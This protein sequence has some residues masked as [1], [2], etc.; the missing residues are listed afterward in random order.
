MQNSIN[1]RKFI[2]MGLAIAGGTQI[3]RNHLFSQDLHSNQIPGERIVHPTEQTISSVNNVIFPKKLKANDIIAIVSP[4]S[5]TNRWEVT[6]TVNFLKSLN[7]KVE[8]GKSIT[9]QTNNYR[10]LAASDKDR[11][12]EFNYYINREDISAIIASRGGY[13]S[14]RIIEDI[15]FD[16]ISKNP[17][18]FIGFSDFTFIL[19]AISKINNLATYYGPV[20]ISSFTDYT[21]KYFINAL[22]ENQ[23]EIYIVSKPEA[24]VI[25]EGK[26]EGRLI[27]G[28]LTM[29]CATLG[30]PYEIMT[31]NCILMLEDI[32]VE[33]YEIDRMLNQ[34]KLAG[35]F[36][37][38]QGIVLGYFSNIKRRKHFYPNFSYTILEV[39]EQV[40]KPYNIPIIANFP[41]GHI[42]E[43]ATFPILGYSTLNTTNK[44]LTINNS[45]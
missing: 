44:S 21:K 40:L 45:K 18:I 24:I 25:N 43:Q 4:S 42:S 29:C 31:D 34:L 8:I 11:I 39:F 19:N 17:K 23:K 2:G 37:N 20:G 33:A 7:L 28:N 12:E 1:R 38:L 41:F 22:F 6:K 10:Y 3:F 36:N 30:T 13:G 9:K 16:S 26:S 27:G 14:M 15:N 35:K 5:P 32:N